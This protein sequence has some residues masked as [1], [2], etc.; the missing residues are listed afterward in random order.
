MVP[1]RGLATSKQPGVKGKKT[2]LTYAL[3]ANADGSD[4]LPALIIGKAAQPRVSRVGWRV[5]LSCY[6]TT[7]PNFVAGLSQVR[8]ERLI[9]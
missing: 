5:V 9:E 6:L 7:T 2:R 4:K 1:D 3:T 8:P